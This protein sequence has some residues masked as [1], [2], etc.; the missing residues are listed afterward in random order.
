MKYRV[1]WF[2]LPKVNGR[3]IRSEELNFFAASYVFKVVPVVVKMK[4]A[5]KQKHES[6]ATKRPPFGEPI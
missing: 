2:A 4:Y 1:A 3:L 6:Q 5:V